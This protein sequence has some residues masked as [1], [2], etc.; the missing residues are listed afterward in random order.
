MKRSAKRNDRK[1]TKRHEAKGNA[2]TR[3]KKKNEKRKSLKIDMQSVRQ[4]NPP[5]VIEGPPTD[6]WPGV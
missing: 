1:Q 4:I 3:L 2:K 5:P 6:V